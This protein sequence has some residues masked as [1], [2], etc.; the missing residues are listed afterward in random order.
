MITI[1]D[2]SSNVLDR[3]Y[4]R[5]WL[6]G[7][8]NGYDQALK[9][10][11]KGES[12]D[13]M[14]QAGLTPTSATNTQL[15]GYTDHTF[16]YDDQ[17]RVT[18]ENTNAFGSYG[19][20]YTTNPNGLSS[21]DFNHWNAKTVETLPDG[22]EN[23]VYTNFQK[24]AMLTAFNDVSASAKWITYS[25]FNDK[26]YVTLKALPSALSGYDDTY[27]DL[28]E[29]DFGNA[30]YIKDG[31]GLVLTN[32][33]AS[34]TTAT[35]TSAGDAKGWLSS[36]NLS[37]GE[38]GTAVPQSAIS[39][40]KRTVLGVDYFSLA[41]QTVYTNT[42]GT[43]SL[44]TSYS[45]TFQ[46]STAQP[47]QITQTNPTVSTSKNGSNSAPSSVT[48]FDAFGQPIWTKDEAGYL[49]YRAYDQVTGALTKQIT[50]VD[51][52]QTTTFSSLPSG[53]ST[54]SGGGLHL[55]TS[56]EVDSLGR[57]TKV[58]YPN[59]RVDY[60]VYKDDVHEV[61]TY[62]AWDATNN[63]PLL[64]ITVAREDKA[65]GY[66]EVLTMSATPSV[67]S[68]KPTGT[69]SISSLDRGRENRL[70]SVPPPSEPDWR[71]SRIRLSG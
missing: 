9:F 60:I 38:T 67:A 23:I 68:G 71:F 52:A 53:W 10:V 46:G 25:Q 49:T 64:P 47:A 1:Q 50:D 12:Y 16:E 4:F 22:N 32:T 65:R 19:F 14:V 61:R 66:R 15:A 28:V 39:Y 40:I 36:S 33:Y 24:Q 43:G 26:G 45:Y 59:G 57:A 30:T 34:S 48:V 8:T 21:T 51:T 41:N 3:T 63:V 70:V 62:P 13:R 2:G 44:T 27:N 31:E 55:T 17:F 20:S 69:E 37:R 56:Y 35:S 6:T 7:Q 58:T 29:W 54:P 42:N 18:L 5:Y 11:L